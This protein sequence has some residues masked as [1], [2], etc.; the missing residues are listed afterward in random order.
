MKFTYYSY[1]FSFIIMIILIP[2]LVLNKSYNL[3]ESTKDISIKINNKYIWPVMG[4]YKI[5][6]FFGI[7][8]SPTKGASSNHGGIDI[9]APMGANIVAIM[10]GK[11]SF[12]GFLGAGGYTI[13][14]KHINGLESIYCHVDNKY[15]PKNNTNVYQGKIIGKVGPKN[16]FDYPNNKYFD[17]KG[18]PT[19]GATTGPHL[20]FGIRKN[21]KLC[22][23]LEFIKK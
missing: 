6:S 12:T 13:I 15:F 4:Y 21:G 16:I 22:N 17:V 1:I 2:I 9:A 10:D 11:V 14:I 23:P 18:I 7:R 3:N 20:H 5:T 19:N 8:E